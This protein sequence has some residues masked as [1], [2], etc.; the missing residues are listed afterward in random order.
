MS[1][2]PLTGR[3]LEV[4]HQPV[5]VG[6]GNDL[7]Q[8]PAVTA[9]LIENLLSG[10]D[11]ERNRGVFPGCH[12][13]M[14]AKSA[15][16]IA[17][18]FALESLEEELIF[19][20]PGLPIHGLRRTPLHCAPFPLGQTTPHAKFDFALEGFYEAFKTDGTAK[21]HLA[22]MPLRGALNEHG[23][24]IALAGPR[25]GCKDGPTL[26]FGNAC[27]HCFFPPTPMGRFPHFLSENKRYKVP[28]TGCR[29]CGM[30]AFFSTIR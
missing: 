29:P 13:S 26:D 23:V 15:G 5:S 4:S 22:C 1:S 19:L 9:P 28:V 27:R 8:F 17:E 30:K 2:R 3:A 24:N 6:P 10:V 18:S 20:Q 25:T 21:A 12:D 16:S 11:D 7:N 14:L